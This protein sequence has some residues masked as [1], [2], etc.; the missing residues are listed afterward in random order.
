MV[1]SSCLCEKAEGKVPPVFVKPAKDRKDNAINALFVDKADHR[2]GASAHLHKAAFDHI[3]G[4][5]LSPEVAGEAEKAQQLRQ[6]FLQ[7]PQHRGIAHL[8]M[9]LENPK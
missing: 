8:P 9:A 1:M 3:G 6:I 7:L 5:Q 2:P 4:A